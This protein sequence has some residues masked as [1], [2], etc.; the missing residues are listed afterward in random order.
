MLHLFPSSFFLEWL[1][2]NKQSSKKMIVACRIR[3]LSPTECASGQRVCCEVTADGIISIHRSDTVGSYLKSQAASFNDYAFD[4]VFDA[5]ATQQEVYEQT[6]KPFIA[7]VV[8]GLNVTVFAYGSTSAGK[9]HTM[10]GSTRQDEAAVNAEAGIIP[11][12]VADVFKLIDEK[13]AASAEGEGEDGSCDSFEISIS[14]VEVYNETILDLLNPASDN[15]NNKGLA[16]REDQEKGIVVIAGVTEQKVDTLAGVMEILALGS[17]NRKTESTNANQTSSRSHAI[18]QL[19]IS[20]TFCSKTTGDLVVV[21]SKLSLID[22]AGSERASATSNS[23]VRL[24][25]G[26]NINKSLL[27]LANC[28][29]VLAENHTTAGKKG[30]V[31]FRDSKLTLLLKNSLE[32]NSN[33]VMI[34]N[35]CPSN[36]TYEDSH[37]TLKYAN[38]AKNI[39]VNPTMK[40]TYKENNHGIMNERLMSENTQLRTRIVY[41]EQVIRD[42]RMGIDRPMNEPINGY[43]N[44]TTH[45]GI[46]LQQPTTTAAAM[47]SF[48]NNHHLTNPN[49]VSSSSSMTIVPSAAAP[50]PIGR[51]GNRRRTLAGCVGGGGAASRPLSKGAKTTSFEN[52]RMKDPSVVMEEGAGIVTTCCYDSFS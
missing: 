8:K 18:L 19:T 9:T 33:L 35:L 13:I 49:A 34:C 48:S 16:L 20:H 25:E 1:L 29:N 31:K 41:L 38:R 47:S 50:I 12:A 30:N 40:E 17:K 28:I 23:G 4:A 37:N 5:N 42:L 32:G 22:L 43:E 27:A 26:A 44:E 45:V 39:K 24:H 15:N 6:T 11:N 51:G 7:N 2:T 36:A 10:F 3:P 46:S 52:S 14:F 21:E